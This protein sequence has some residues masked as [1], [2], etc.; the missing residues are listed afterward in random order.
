MVGTHPAAAPARVAAP[1]DRS[2]SESEPLTLGLWLI[3]LFKSIG[4]VL[5]WGTFGLLLAAGRED[6]RNFFSILA[7]RLFRGDP[8]DLIVR[9]MVHNLEF[10]TRAI[11][12]RVAIVTAGYATIVSAEAIG[13]ILRKWWAEWLVILVT[14]SFIPFEVYEMTTRPGFLKAGTLVVNLAILWYLLKRLFDKR[15]RHAAGGVL[16]PDA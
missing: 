16:V 8:P 9:F 3:I 2:N 4:A 5:L 12:I 1:P 11:V 6:P 14:T 7:F 10:V 15:R 13:L